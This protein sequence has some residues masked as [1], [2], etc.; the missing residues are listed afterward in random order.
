MVAMGTEE[1]PPKWNS[2]FRLQPEPEE[3]DI[4]PEIL[5][6]VKAIRRTGIETIAS[7]AAIGGHLIEY[8]S[9]IQLQLMDK[10]GA[11]V[12]EKIR[13]FA[14][15][16]TN[17]LRAELQNPEIALMLVSAEAWY[18]DRNTVSMDA[19]RFGVYRIQLVNYRSDAEIRKSW[20]K[21]ASRFTREVIS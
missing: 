7:N 12:A 5:P 19:P 20:V 21:V 10:G 14:Q 4:Q 11:Q 13:L 17:E 15:E 6:A 16:I 9:Y 2:K 8:G 18:E 1:G 3:S